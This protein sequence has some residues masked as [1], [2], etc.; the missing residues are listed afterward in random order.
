VFPPGVQTSKVAADLI[1]TTMRKFFYYQLLEVERDAS[2]EDIKASFRRLARTWHPDRNHGN[3]EAE[4]TFRRINTAYQVLSDEQQRADYDRSP[5]E[6]PECGTH[7]VLTMSDGRWQC[8]HCGCR[9][10]VSG[11][12]ELRAIDAPNS[13]PLRRMRFRAFQATQ[14]SW[15]A[16]FYDREPIMCPYRGPQTNCPAFKA[17]TEGQRDGYLRNPAMPALADQWMRP[18]ADSALIRKC[19]YCGA[20]NPNPSRMN[21][22][23]W[24]CKRPLLDEC[25]HCG[26]PMMYYDIEKGVWRCANSQCS[27]RRFEFDQGTGAW[28]MT[29]QHS[30]PSRKTR[31]RQPRQP[32]CPNCGA[33]LV[34]SEQQNLW[35]CVVCRSFFNPGESG[36]PT[37]S[38]PPVPEFAPKSRRRRSSGSRP[39]RTRPAAEP[40]I[41]KRKG[42]TT[43][44]Y[45]LLAAA[46]G[47][48]IIIGTMVLL[49]MSGALS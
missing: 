49:G 31:A 36:I 6:C 48:I 13:P 40:T 28:R 43:G 24:N 17:V 35:C 9:F 20:L 2:Q 25:P 5:V 11:A 3:S 7:E 1:P 38:E 46:I 42:K 44:D 10:D 14:C 18:S 26:L 15:C 34:Y 27:G 47:L 39:R 16:H 23:C 8:K 22:P 37:P 41:G 12:P 21:E 30:S 19:T 29:V 33:G 45:V 32:A 4:S